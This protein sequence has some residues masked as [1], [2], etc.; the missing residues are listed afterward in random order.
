M[1]C[2]FDA[3][4]SKLQFHVSC[5]DLSSPHAVRA[6]FHDLNQA[7]DALQ[8]R[9]GDPDVK[10][11][12]IHI[13]R[14]KPEAGQAVP[15]Q[16]ALRKSSSAFW[17]HIA[18]ERRYQMH[19]C[20]WLLRIEDTI[21]RSERYQRARPGLWETRSHQFGEETASLLREASD[22]YGFYHSRL[23]AIW[24]RVRQATPDENRPEA[25]DCDGAEKA[26]LRFRRVS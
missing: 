9:L 24:K 1:M 7:M 21:L 12:A 5:S 23:D 15:S 4:A 20:D 19:A 10:Y 16:S 22:T 25:S 13:L 11:A 14:D 2:A 18:S 17:S 3:L 26:V 8:A 6:T